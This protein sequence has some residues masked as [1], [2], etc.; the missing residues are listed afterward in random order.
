MATPNPLKSVAKAK[1]RP[2]T[3]ADTGTGVSAREPRTSTV[4]GWSPARIRTAEIQCGAGNYQLAADLCE[5]MM[6]DSRVSKCIGRLYSAT[7]LPLSFLL[8]GKD[9]K[10]SAKDPTCQALDADWWKMLPEQTMLMIVAWLSLL[11]L[12]LIHVDEWKKDEE[13][14]RV[15][16]VLSVWS[17]RNLRNDPTDGWVVKVADANGNNWG[18]EQKITPG[19]GNWIVLV[20]GSNYRAPVQAPWLG[21]APWW[22]LGKRYS[23]VD[24]A[25][26]SERHGQGQTFISNT[27]TAGSAGL[28]ADTGEELSP[29]KKTQLAQDVAGSGRNGVFVF[30]RGWKGELV[31]DGAKTFETFEKQKDSANSEIEIALVGTNLGSDSSNGSRAREEVWATVDSTK[32]CGMLELIATGFHDQ[33]LPYW[34]AYNPLPGPVPYPHWDTTPPAD[35]KAKAEERKA[36]GE[37][38]KAYVDAGAQIDQIAWFEGEVKLIPGAKRELKKAVAPAPVAAPTQPNPDDNA[39]DDEDGSDDGKGKKPIPPKPPKA[40][41]ELDALHSTQALALAAASAEDAAQTALARGHVYLDRLESECAAHAAKELAPM[42]A[43][44]VSAIAE[45]TDY[46]DAKARI[47]AAYGDELPP[48]KLMKLTESALIMAQLAGR[49]SVE[50]ELAT[51]E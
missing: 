43:A 39:T 42:V 34:L 14:G 29:T 40:L 1:P 21:I 7:A 49:E 8:P 12:C 24:W 32:F 46:E 18:I 6:P 27:M 22:L 35:R 17:P 13:T 47:I 23:P 51:G 25:S 16:P 11:K 50:Q 44:V 2:E 15:L 4:T 33:L 45:A 30:P 36:D 20:F 37:A 28:E 38:L 41:A 26:S 5:A 9:S 10:Q 48:S 3:D 19:D 31:T